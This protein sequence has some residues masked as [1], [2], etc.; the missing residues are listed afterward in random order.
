M[1]KLFCQKKTLNLFNFVNEVLSL[2]FEQVHLS[3]NGAEDNSLLIFDLGNLKFLPRNLPFK[4]TEKQ[5]KLTVDL[6]V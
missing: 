4:I 6:N 3:L 1:N 2:I 5:T